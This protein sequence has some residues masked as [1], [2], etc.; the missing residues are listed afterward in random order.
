MAFSE[1][2]V[3]SVLCVFAVVGHADAMPISVCM[4]AC[5]CPP[6][7]LHTSYRKM[8]SVSHPL[9]LALY[10]NASMA[11]EAAAALHVLGINREQISV[12]AHRHADALTL[13][14]RMDAMPGVDLEDS[15]TAARL[16]EL[17]G[18]VL[19]AIALV[20]PGIGPIVAAGPLAAELGEAAGHAVGSL[21]SVLKSA[22][23]PQGPAEAL[24]REVAQGA[25]LLGVHVSA[26]DVNR[27]R[28][29][30][31][32]SGATRLEMVTWG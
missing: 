15:R 22:G 18:Q 28:D 12:V 13:A 27:V 17:G 24:Q 7:P 31:S 6:E 2:V 14:D 5:S 4:G 8:L 9:A 23:L 19:A 25:V 20:M 29:S 26:L 21:A 10:S 30:L 1:V 32:A 3:I 16:G 11:A